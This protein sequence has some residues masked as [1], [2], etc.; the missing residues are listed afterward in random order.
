MIEDTKEV[1]TAPARHDKKPPVVIGN[2][3][4]VDSQ[5]VSANRSE[6]VTRA[7]RPNVSTYRGNASVFTT[8]LMIEFTAV[9][10]K[11]TTAKTITVCE[12]D[13]AS[14]EIDGTTWTVTHSPAIVA[15]RRAMKSIASFLRSGTMLARANSMG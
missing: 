11:A 13:D 9:N 7:N 1:M 3:S 2:P 15:K 10:T 8:G 4:D 6:F 12:A 5:P 14:I